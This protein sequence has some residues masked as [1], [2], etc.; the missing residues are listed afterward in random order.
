MKENVSAFR[1]KLQTYSKST[2]ERLSDIAISWETFK[3]M[4]E[5]VMESKTE[6]EVM[7]KLNS[8]GK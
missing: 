2:M 6:E 5:I 3:K 1:Q 4:K 8:L 7:K